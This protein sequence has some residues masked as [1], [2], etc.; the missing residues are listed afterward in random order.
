M[1]RM[2]GDCLNPD[3]LSRLIAGELCGSEAQKAEAHVRTCADCK[4]ALDALARPFPDKGPSPSPDFD[5]EVPPTALAV[6]DPKPAQRVP[7]T[8]LV[9]GPDPRL[10][11]GVRELLRS[12]LRFFAAV[13]FLT[14]G[15]YAVLWVRL[16]LREPVTLLID[17]V[18]LGG[19]TLMLALAGGLALYLR[20]REA[21]SVKRLRWIEVVTFVATVLFFTYCEAFVFARHDRPLI[22][23][24]AFPG[25]AGML[26][27]SLSFSWFVLL[28]A[29]GLLIPNTLRRCATV[30]GLIAAWPVLLSVFLA[31]QEWPL[32]S[33]VGFVL[34]TAFCMALGAALAVYGSHR[35][36][37][38]REQ[39]SQARKLGH[40][41]L[42]RRLGA[43]GMGEVWL[44]EHVLLRRPCAV[45]LIRPDHVDDPHF[46]R[47]FEREVRATAAL[48]HPNTVE[49]YDYGTADDGTFYYAMEYLPGLSLQEL[50][51]Q[52]GPLPAARAVHLLRQVCGA[53]GEAHR[54]GLVHRDVKPSNVLVCVRGGRCDVAKLLDFGLVRVPQ[55]GGEET[56]TCD[57]AVAGTP[58]YMSPEQARGASV[59]ARS[60]LYSLGAVA[61]FL[62][63]GKPPFVRHTAAQ[64]MA[65]HLAET[66][67]APDQLREDLPGDV[68]AVVLRCLEKDPARRFQDA[69]E[70]ER[71]LAGCACAGNWT[72]EGSEAAQIQPPTQAG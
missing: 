59:D 67:T 35:I 34:E 65:A 18:L 69:G 30:V 40:Y 5:E 13:S 22:S 42:N 63:T 7:P 11:H 24:D 28:V 29:Y 26:G 62:L 55:G 52:A 61:Y 23:P 44:A 64:T 48:S 70:M 43:G 51:E 14:Y 1:T 36:E 72:P 58:A 20:R 25:A 27:R 60:D 19:C 54:A 38:L 10:T 56:L 21:P 3:L 31:E 68:Q 33:R 12:R 71:A 37:T 50:V 9:L 46:L 41:R 2:T 4:R 57:G 39:V 16:I 47:R 53:L 66:V 17:V 8:L 6:T 32:E 49:I 45:K 15:F